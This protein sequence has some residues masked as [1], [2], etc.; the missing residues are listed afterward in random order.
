MAYAFS[1][2]LQQEH[3]LTLDNRGKLV[4]SGVEDVESFDEQAIVLV[5]VRGVLIVRGNG[6]H[7]QSLDLQGGCVTVDGVIDSLVY[8][9][10]RQTGSLLR[11]LFH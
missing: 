1:E 5:T 4:V 9:L 3:K 11:R 7:L 2:P 10:P 8:E 6:L